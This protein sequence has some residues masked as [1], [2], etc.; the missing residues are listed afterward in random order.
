LECADLSALFSRGGLA[1]RYGYHELNAG[2]FCDRSQKTKALT[3]QRTPNN[4]DSQV[5][6]RGPFWMVSA[7]SCYTPS[8]S[9]RILNPSQPFIVHMWAREFESH[10]DRTS[11]GKG[12]VTSWDF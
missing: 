1:P 2:N 8:R 9:C 12:S 11:L 5:Y 10:E 7:D 6:R 4:G 3:G